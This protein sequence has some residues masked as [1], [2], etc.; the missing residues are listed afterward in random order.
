M[1]KEEFLRRFK[2]ENIN[3]ED[4]MLILDK[5]S[6]ASLVLGCAYDEGVWKV[7]ETT[8][9]TG[10]FVIKEFDNEDEAFDYFY[11]V[12]KIQHNYTTKNFYL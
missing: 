6:N 7:Y 10:H 3:L 1:T 11:E 5:I 12:V 8:E 2:E 4:Y 9:R